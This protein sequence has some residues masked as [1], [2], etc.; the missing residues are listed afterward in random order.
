MRCAD[1]QEYT[2]DQ[3]TVWRWWQAFQHDFAARMDW[4]VKGPAEANHNPAVVVDG[5]PGRGGG[6]GEGPARAAGTLSAAGTADPGGHTLRDPWS[7]DPAAG[8]WRGRAEAAGGAGAE[9][10]VAVPRADGGTAHAL[11]AAEYD[12]GPS[13]TAYRRAILE[14]DEGGVGAGGFG[15]SPP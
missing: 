9:A 15:A 12:G 4:C 7:A 11:L 13:R 6:A 5:V 14:V 1:G 3:A 8:T 2:S 10:T